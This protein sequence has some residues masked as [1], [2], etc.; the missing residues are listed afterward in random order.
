[1][2]YIIHQRRKRKNERM[3]QEVTRALDAE[4]LEEE[5]GMLDGDTV[6]EYSLNDNPYAGKE[7]EDD[8][9]DVWPRKISFETSSQRSFGLTFCSDTTAAESPRTNNTSTFPAGTCSS[10]EFFS[11][12]KIP[13]PSPSARLTPR[14]LPSLAIQTKQRAFPSPVYSKVQDEENDSPDISPSTYSQSSCHHSGHTHDPPRP[15][16]ESTRV[17]PRALPVPPLQ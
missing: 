11:R 12:T 6:K 8:R 17:I 7:Y 16:R 14:Q 9:G 10:S 15:E 13:D 3:R 4:T 5:V 1:M 2:G